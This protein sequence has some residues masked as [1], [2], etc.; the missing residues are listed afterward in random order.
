MITVLSANIAESLKI[1]LLLDF[2]K[3][4]GAKLIPFYLLYLQRFSLLFAYLKKINFYLFLTY[5]S[6]ATAIYWYYNFL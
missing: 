4:V 3:N 1:F 6:E 5:Y 2:P